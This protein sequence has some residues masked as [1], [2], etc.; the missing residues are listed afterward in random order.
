MRKHAVP[1][2][3]AL[4][5]TDWLGLTDGDRLQLPQL[6]GFALLTGRAMTLVVEH[7]NGATTPFI[8]SIEFDGV[9]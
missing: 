2:T 6:D 8:V 5:L 9:L 3:I 1:F 4:T 7:E